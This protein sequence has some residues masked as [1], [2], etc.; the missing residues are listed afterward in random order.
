MFYTTEN[1]VEFDNRKFTQIKRKLENGKFELGGYIECGA[2]IRGEIWIN[3]DSYVYGNCV[4]DGKIRIHK[5]TIIKNTT[6]S[7]H[8]VIGSNCVIENSYIQAVTK[9]ATTINNN[10]K[11]YGQ[12]FKSTGKYDPFYFEDGIIQTDSYN[13]NILTMT[14]NYCKINCLFLTYEKA[15][16]YLNDEDKWSYM[17]LNNLDT[18]QV[19]YQD[20]KKW[21]Y[22][23]CE[24]Q[25]KR[26]EGRAK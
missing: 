19:F 17:K 21:L 6:L 4:L 9:Y 3:Q 15:W 20:T 24:K 26:K 16:E 5:N 10:C 1:I 12:A 23:W 11:I 25:L 8:M 22:Y 2:I 14:N 13:N 7:G 18:P